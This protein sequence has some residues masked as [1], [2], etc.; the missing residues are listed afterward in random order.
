MPA[1][2][3]RKFL[4]QVE[5]IFHEGGPLAARPPKRGAIVAVIANPFAGRYVQEITGFMDDL[6]P[7]GLDMARRLIDAIGEG[8]SAIEG[9]GKGAI[10]GA[11][12]ELEHGAL[13]HNPGGYAM[14]EL[15]G[16]A[17]AIVP[18]TKKVGGPGTRIDIPITHINAS[19]VRSHFDAIEVGV[20]DAPRADEMAVILAMTTGARVHAR[21]GGLAAADIKGE[22]GL[23]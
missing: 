13:W 22:D 2:V 17:R 18:S 14:R 21:V 19:Y 20:T 9:Y 7:L 12:G 23:R 5:E 6:K 4:V 8:V 15:L 11:A 16:N 3:V 1:V 10:V